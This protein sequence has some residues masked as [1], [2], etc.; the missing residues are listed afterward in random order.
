MHAK[1]SGPEVATRQRSIIPDI[2]FIS[3]VLISVAGLF[4]IFVQQ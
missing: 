4:Y 1:T 2:I 3:M